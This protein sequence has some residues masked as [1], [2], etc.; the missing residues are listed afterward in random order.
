[1]LKCHEKI[2]NERFTVTCG[3]NL[4]KIYYF[5]PNKDQNVTIYIEYTLTALKVSKKCNKS[6]SEC[7]G[8]KD[9]VDLT[10]Y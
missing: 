2:L 10:K 9:F 5:P 6:S 8:C 7:K 4:N 3:Y 1:M